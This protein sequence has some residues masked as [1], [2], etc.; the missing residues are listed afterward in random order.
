MLKEAVAHYHTLLE[1]PEIAGASQR[2]LDEQLESSKLIFGG[3]RLAPYLRPHFVTED[4]WAMVTKTCRTIFDSLQKVK[5]AAIS[6]DNVLRRRA[7][8]ER[9]YTR[10]ADITFGLVSDR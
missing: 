10:F 6:D 1:D 2:M 3:R 5:D 9:K 8:R 7:Y 4:D